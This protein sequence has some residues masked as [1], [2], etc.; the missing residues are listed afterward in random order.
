MKETK[1]I[2]RLHSIT[3]FVIFLPLI[4]V[5]VFLYINSRSRKENFGAIS[6][7]PSLTQSPANNNLDT[8]DVLTSEKSSQTL[9]LNGPSVCTYKDEKA[10]TT[11]YI[12]NKNIYAKQVTSER[13]TEFLL[14]G[15]CV[16]I[17]E[18][19]AA[20]GQ[21]ICGV[22]QYLD[23]FSML[24]STPFFDIKTII[25]ALLGSKT[26]VEVPEKLP[27]LDKVCKKGE[28]DEKLFELPTNIQFKLTEK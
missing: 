11:A 4:L 6:P 13:S 23:L 8:K 16:Y 9:D 5:I 1:D 28:V 18:K 14:K 22:S 26:G 24:S 25:P 7:M 3:R 2:D 12:K 15:D 19:D 17:W 27:D 21:K 10:S 20:N